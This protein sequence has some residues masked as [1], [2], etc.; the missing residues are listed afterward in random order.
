MANWTDLASTAAAA[1]GAFTVTVAFGTAIR[2]AK[3]QREDLL[4]L[5]DEAQ[6]K[7]IDSSDIETLGKYLFED[8]GGVRV[9]D[10]VSDDRVRGRT[11]RAF[12]QVT[13]FIGGEPT[14]DSGEPTATATSPQTLAADELNTAREQILAGDVWNGLALMRRH[15]EI[16]IRQSDPQLE[17]ARMGAGQLITAAVRIG[18]L[19]QEVVPQLRYAVNVANKAIHGEPVELDIALEAVDSADFGLRRIGVSKVPPS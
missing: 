4:R 13:L 6:A 1:S 11:L 16:A 7:A 14:T 12:S 15:L 2:A 18:A 5:N 17:A 9:S 10:V 3:R 8:I 19:P